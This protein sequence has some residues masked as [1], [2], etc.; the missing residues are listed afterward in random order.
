MEE[1]KKKNKHDGARSCHEDLR[2]AM[3]PVNYRLTGEG[4]RRE[5]PGKEEDE[6]NG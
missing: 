6:A 2:D 1:K 3:T 4:W 5:R